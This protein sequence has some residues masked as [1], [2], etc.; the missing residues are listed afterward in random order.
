MFNVLFIYIYR[1]ASLH[2]DTT[3]TQ[4]F[5]FIFLSV[6]VCPHASTGRCL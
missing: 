5:C 2:W 6:S 1:D 3:V 4:M